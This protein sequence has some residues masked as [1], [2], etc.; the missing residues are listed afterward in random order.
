L[1]WCEAHREQHEAKAVPAS[2]V[3]SWNKSKKKQERRKGKCQRTEDPSRTGTLFLIGWAGRTGGVS[4]HPYR[5]NFPFV[6]QIEC[7]GTPGGQSTDERPVNYPYRKTN[8]IG[9]RPRR[10]SFSCA[11][12]TKAPED[13]LGAGRTKKRTKFRGHEGGSGFKDRAHFRQR[14]SSAP[15]NSPSSVEA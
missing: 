1:D 15:N 12:G 3:E 5:G 8:A 10:G 6:T 14:R 2:G 13:A 11:E 4:S 9:G 7:T